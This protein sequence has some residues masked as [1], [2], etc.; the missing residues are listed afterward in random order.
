[1]RIEATTDAGGALVP[2]A[3]V[4]GPAAVGI[5]A[6]QLRQE[7]RVVVVPGGTT[8]SDAAGQGACLTS[9]AAKIA[10]TTGDFDSVVTIVTRLGFDADLDCAASAV[11]AA[12]PARKPRRASAPTTR[13]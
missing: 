4:S 11:R 2:R 1:V 3:L 10:M 12:M 9:D 13:P 6:G 8:S 7:R 5:E